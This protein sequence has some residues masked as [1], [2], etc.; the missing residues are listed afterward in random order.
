MVQRNLD[1]KEFVI[2]PRLRYFKPHSTRTQETFAEEIRH[3]LT[4]R[5]KSIPPKF[6]YDLR[7]SELFEGICGLPEYYPTRTEISMLEQNS[8][9]L[10]ECVGAGHRLVELGSGAS[11]KT[12][13]ILDIMKRSHGHHTV[14]AD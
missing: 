2:N 3:G 13:T 9:D 7:G 14:C 11:V 5:P 1:Y 10:H 4:A 12:R 8:A 6:F